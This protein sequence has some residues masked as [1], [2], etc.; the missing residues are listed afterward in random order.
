MNDPDFFMCVAEAYAADEI[1]STRFREMLTAWQDGADWV[2][3]MCLLEKGKV[4]S[5]FRWRDTAYGRIAHF[6]RGTVSL[7]KKGH[8]GGWI[9][10]IHRCP[11]HFDEPKEVMRSPQE[12][13]YRTE[14]EAKVAADEAVR[15]LLCTSD[16]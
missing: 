9:W 15:G 13:V 5:D 2:E 6:D 7:I 3:L 4:N 14:E 1:D 10:V 8:N 11:R 12:T 16:S